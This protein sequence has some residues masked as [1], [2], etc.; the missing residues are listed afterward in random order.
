MGK[1][2]VGEN[3]LLTWCQNN[4]EWG[5]QLI[6]EWVG[7]DGEGNNIEMTEVSKGN[8]RKKLLWRCNKNSKHK[9][10]ATANDR[11]HA[12]KNKRT[13]CPYCKGKK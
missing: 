5:Q 1:L 4:G 13:G 6:N 3:D 2:I 7:L 10:L 11:T 9:W 12:N 8:P